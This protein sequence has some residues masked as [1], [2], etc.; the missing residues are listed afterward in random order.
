MTSTTRHLVMSIEGALRNRAFDGFVIDNKPATRQQAE[1]FLKYRQAMGDRLLDMSGGECE[2][3]SAQTGCPG[4]PCS[5][6]GHD[7]TPIT[8][9]VPLPG[10]RVLTRIDDGAGVRNEQ[11]LKRMKPGNSLWFFADGSG[12][13]Y[14]SPTHWKR[15]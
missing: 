5:D 7:W 8:D 15:R 6:G 4:H 10:E 9:D 1:T 2:G 11:V 14:Y 3:F 12:Y 13:V